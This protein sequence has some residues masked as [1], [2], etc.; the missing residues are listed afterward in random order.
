MMGYASLGS[1]GASRRIGCVVLARRDRARARGRFSLRRQVLCAGSLVVFCDS[2][3][4]KAG[5]DAICFAR[6]WL[7]E[8]AFGRPGFHGGAS[9]G[10]RGIIRIGASEMCKGVEKEC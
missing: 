5:V 2:R 4:Q 10:R 7:G 3:L 6:A 9:L 8:W 1:E